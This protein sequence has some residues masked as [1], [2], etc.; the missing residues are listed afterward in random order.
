MPHSTPGRC[1][2]ESLL[3]SACNQDAAHRAQVRH[4][5]T[6]RHAAQ[7]SRRQQGRHHR[8]H[9]GGHQAG[10]G[11][12]GGGHVIDWRERDGDGGSPIYEN[13]GESALEFG[14]PCTSDLLAPD[15]HD[16]QAD[17]PFEID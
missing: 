4:Q 5:V 11:G 6:H 12:H 17:K 13:V 9:N 1:G 2:N 14:Y 3:R 7:E 8:G 15:L 10:L 16:F